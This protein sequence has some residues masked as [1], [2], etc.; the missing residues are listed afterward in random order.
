M[1]GGGPAGCAAAITL[2]RQG[3]RV[4][5]F[6]RTGY[7]TARIGETFPPEIG[8]L[9]ATLG[10]W[11]RFVGDGHLPSPG[12]LAAWGHA[13]PHANDF[14]VNPH[15]PGWRVDRRRF[16]EMLAGAAE[17]AGAVVYRRTDVRACERDSSGRWR[18]TATHDGRPARALSAGVLAD[19]T[20]RASR[21]R[22]QVGARRVA[23]DR[24]VA[25][26]G[27]LAPGPDGP[28]PDRR[29]LIEATEHGWWYSARLPDDRLVLAFHT[30]ARPG[31]RAGWDGF[32][33]AAP[34]TAARAG[35][36]VGGTSVGRGRPVVVAATSQRREPVGA[37]DWVAVGDAA[38]A[39]DP[40]AGLGVYRA[41]ESGMAAGEALVARAAGDHAA[42]AGFAGAADER[43]ARYLVQRAMYYRAETRWPDAPFWSRRQAL[44]G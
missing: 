27:F 40:I 2:A 22:R 1:V 25:V 28:A 8:P 33:A 38:A 13:E 21:L 15:G 39:H 4:A 10:V 35:A 37:A 14:I 36:A 19:A 12:I 23:C 6:E 3:V 30:D 42:V 7:D 43:F 17:A 26:V 41:L 18:L 11:D 31:L 44:L 20:G 16:D 24:L 29:A 32:M 9:L 34:H 5:L